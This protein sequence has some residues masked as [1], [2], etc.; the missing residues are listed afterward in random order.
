[1]FVG[2]GGKL[3]DSSMILAE[4]LLSHSDLIKSR[5]VIELG[6]GLGLIGIV[7]S[8]LGAEEVLVTDMEVKFAAPFTVYHILFAQP[9]VPRFVP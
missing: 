9:L 8:L 5:R 1:M 6:S 7:S 3:W 4:Y 2:I